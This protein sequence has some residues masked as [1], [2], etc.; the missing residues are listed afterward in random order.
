QGITI[1][2]AY[3]YFS[4]ARCK[5]IIADT[6]GYEQYMRNMAIGASIADLAIILVDATKGLLTQTRRHVYIT[7]LL[8][9]R[10][11]VAAIQKMDLA[12][13]GE[14]VFDNLERDF[15]LLAS[16]LG[17]PSV[18]CIPISALAGD[19]VVSPSENMIWYSGPTLLGHLETVDFRQARSLN[20][21]RF[22]VQY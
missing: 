5:F 2:V 18:Q 8:G 12:G 6:L 15:V 20:V 11:V 1:D 3:R 4:T 14:E 21:V 10:R 7:S 17:I 22:P 9:I 13:Y 19:N 16:Q